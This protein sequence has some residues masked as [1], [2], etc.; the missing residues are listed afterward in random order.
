M[1][2]IQILSMDEQIQH[3]VALTTDLEADFH[4]IQRRRLK[5]LGPFERTKQISKKNKS[6]VF[7]YL[8]KL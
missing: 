4:P 7:I 2:I 5:K 8:F 3:V 1:K 6:Y